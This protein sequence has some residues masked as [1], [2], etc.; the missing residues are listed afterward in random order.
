MQNV[1]SF[2]FKNKKYVSNPFDFEALCLINDR[3]GEDGSGVMRI[4]EG[5]VEHMFEGT[6]ATAEI[7]EKLPPSTRARLGKEV[8]SM[9][10]DALKNE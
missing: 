4:T 1:L 10:I 6:E 2:N 3:H 7:F 5:A 9:Y 8:W